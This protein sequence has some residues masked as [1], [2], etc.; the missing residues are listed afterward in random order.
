MED[1]RLVWRFPALAPGRGLVR[2]TLDGQRLAARVSVFERRALFLAPVISSNRHEGWDPLCYLFGGTPE[3]LALAG[4]AF[5]KTRQLRKM[6]HDRGLPITWLIDQAVAAE[7]GELLTGWHLEHGD[8]VAALPSSFIHHNAINLNLAPD[9]GP[10]VALLGETVRGVEEALGCLVR[11]AGVDQWVGSVGSRF[12]RAA[13]GLGLIGLWGLGFDHATCDTSMFHRGA[14]WD[15]YKPDP[16]EYRR[17]AREAAELWA[18]QWTTRDV[19]N[20]V[21]TPNGG[22]GGATLFSTDPDDIRVA[23][24]MRHQPDYWTALLDDWRRNRPWNDCGVFLIHQEDHDCH[25]PE[26]ADYLRYFLDALPPDVTPATLEEIA[27]WLNLVHAPAG[28]PRVALLLEDVLRCRDRVDLLWVEKPADWPGPGERYPAHLAYYDRDRMFFTARPDRLPVRWF[29]YRRA[30]RAPEDGVLPEAA[31]PRV[32]VEDERWEPAGG[33]SLRYRATLTADV[34]CP[35]CPWTVW[36]PPAGGI[37]AGDRVLAATPACVAMLL[38][39]AAGR[40]DYA[41]EMGRNP[42]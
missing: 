28:H 2:A 22:A 32:A 11:V 9:D 27:L 8:G 13:R 39:I 12:V 3:G 29:D 19:L 18:F 31:V 42:G 24:I 1:G 26:N 6:Y 4:H 33:G 36:D 37:A 10:A 35:N 25:F 7:A 16:E 40:R 30:A 21:R 20:T 23:G 5:P 38:D 41:V 17:P 15:V 34:D 14:P